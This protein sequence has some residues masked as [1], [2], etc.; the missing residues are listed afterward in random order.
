MS[1]FVIFFLVL[2]SFAHAQVGKVLKVTGEKALLESGSSQV[3]LSV[4][5]NL[6]LGDT[7]SSGDAIVQLLIL[8]ATQISLSKNTQIKISEHF[9][10]ENQLKERAF[11]IIGL[12][13]G[14]IRVNVSKDASQ[15]ID[16]K[17]ESEGVSFA[18]RGT[19]FELSDEGGEDVELDVIEGQV[20][21]SSP[22]IQSFV[23]EIV[24][25]SEGLKFSRKQKNFFRR[26]MTLRFKNHPGF[27]KG[28]FFLKKW[29]ERKR[30]KTQTLK[31]NKVRRKKK[32]R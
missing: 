15:E 6:N 24:K 14:L 32:D 21:V 20:E 22:Y 27:A 4:D 17:Y 7:I 9:I 18:V 11:S 3:P 29:K 10:E 23:P 2:T 26:K 5:Q 28:D 31:A 1:K 19:E 12:I 8:P 30:Q 25:R 13:K 16:Q